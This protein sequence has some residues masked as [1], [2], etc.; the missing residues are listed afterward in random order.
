[1]SSGTIAARGRRAG[2]SPW[3]ERL[4]RAGLVAK[5]VLYAIVGMLAIEVARGS[6]EESPDK[7]G[8]LRTIAEQPFGKALLALLALGL[9]GY[10]SWQLARAI[11]DRDGNGEGAKGL[12]KR[13]AALARAGWYGVLCGLTLSVLAGNGSGSDNEQQ[14]T[15]GVFDHTGGRYLVYAA[16][17]AFLGAAAF[18]A[19]RGIT[20]KFNKKLKQGEM[21][22]AGEAAATTVGVLGHL[23]RAVVFGL[24]GLFL[25]KAAWEYDPTQARGLDGA[26]LELVQQPYGEFLLGAVGV[27]LMAYALYCFVQARY[28]RI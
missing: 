12:A 23:A 6:R 28:R 27:G 19:Y 25:V 15:A 17:L 13:A 20:C 8:A 2:R 22:E 7:S 26:L 9:A 16:G 11:L 5:G 1:M 3:V 14:K 21:S 4:G 10:A 24:I 18:N